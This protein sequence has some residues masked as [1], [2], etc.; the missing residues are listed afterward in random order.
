MPIPTRYEETSS[1]VNIRNSLRY[2]TETLIYLVQSF[3]RQR[4]I[5]DVIDE[6]LAKLEV[7]RATSPS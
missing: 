3:A 1:S 7:S 4:T 2:V 5:R 6:R